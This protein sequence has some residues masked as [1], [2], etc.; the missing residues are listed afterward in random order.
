MSDCQKCKLEDHKR[1]QE[2]WSSTQW[3]DYAK[4][5]FGNSVDETKF[6]KLYYTWYD[7]GQSVKENCVK[8][9]ADPLFGFALKH[10]CGK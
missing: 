8:Q 5:L 1:E 9:W 2:M 4:S 7:A 6:H 3:A 10:S